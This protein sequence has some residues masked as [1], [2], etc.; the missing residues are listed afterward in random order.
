MAE[1]VHHACDERVALLTAAFLKAA[2]VI[3]RT[4]YGVSTHEDPSLDRQRQIR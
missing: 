1:T 2:P 4:H 3:W